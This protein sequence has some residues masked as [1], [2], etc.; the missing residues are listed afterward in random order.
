MTRLACGLRIYVYL[1]TYNML[2]FD[3]PH[4]LHRPENPPHIILINAPHLRIRCL[5]HHNRLSFL[6]KQAHL[7]AEVRNYHVFGYVKPMKILALAVRYTFSKRILQCIHGYASTL[8]V[9][10]FGRSRLIAIRR[11]LLVGARIT[12]R[13]DMLRTQC[14]HYPHRITDNCHCHRH[15]PCRLTLSY[16]GPQLGLVR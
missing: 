11:G 1:I 2:S 3:F 8:L 13:G 10:H 15:R 16:Q 9:E 12:L 4:P 7:S 5:L 6:N 14:R